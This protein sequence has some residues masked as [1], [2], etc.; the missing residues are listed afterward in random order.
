VGQDFILRPILNRPGIAELR[1]WR[2]Q[3]HSLYLAS[4]YRRRLPHLQNGDQPVFLT[5]RL[6]GS[7]PPNRTFPS[8]SSPGRAFVAMD[9]LLDAAVCGPLHLRRPETATVAVETIQYG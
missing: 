5:W 3:R 4:F 9:R 2:R 7:L 8:A 6:I 1:T